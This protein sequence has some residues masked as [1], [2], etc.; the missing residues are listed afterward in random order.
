M[1]TNRKWRYFSQTGHH[2][3]L[4]KNYTMKVRYTRNDNCYELTNYAATNNPI[5]R[6]EEEVN[7]FKIRVKNHIS[8]LCEIMGFSFFND[9]YQILVS[10]KDRE[11]FELFYMEKMESKGVSVAL[12]EI[13]LSTYILSQEMANVQSGYAKWFNFKHNRYGVVFGRRY[14]KELIED[15][16]TLKL[17]LEEIN[18]YVK[19]WDFAEF[20]SYVN[21]F[22]KRL[23]YLKKVALSSACLYEDLR[24]TDP[25]IDTFLHLELFL[26]RG[27]YSSKG[28]PG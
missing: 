28:A 27:R 20:W 16:E 5:F 10:L 21:N 17:C 1:D 8:P 6:S 3:L 26:L 18:Q 4:I 23:N 7:N 14:T 9:H 15:E 12:G 25:I 11:T 22:L 19:I 2:F 13:P 24:E